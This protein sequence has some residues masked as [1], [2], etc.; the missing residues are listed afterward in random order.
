MMDDED[1]DD[2]EEEEEEEVKDNASDDLKAT[3]LKRCTKACRLC[4]PPLYIVTPFCFSPSQKGML[5]HLH[6]N[7]DDVT[8][9]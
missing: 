9:Y 8:W 7:R 1:D 5:K 3:S 2:E 6:H 4:L